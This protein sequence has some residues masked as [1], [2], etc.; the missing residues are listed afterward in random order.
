MFAEQ[1]VAYFCVCILFMVLRGL[2][3]ARE[4]EQ[5]TRID[6]GM[7]GARST[8]P[9]V[10]KPSGPNRGSIGKQLGESF[11]FFVELL[12]IFVK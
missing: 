9:N 3:N 6:F 2:G 10:D 8:F 4:L 1:I 7:A 12:E 5:S 11:A